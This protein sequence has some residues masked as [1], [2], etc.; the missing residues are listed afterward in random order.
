MT[1]HTI[2]IPKERIGVL[3]GP[4]GKV[5][6]DLEGRAGVYIEIDSE[7]GDV[8]IHDENVFEPVLAL[9]VRDVVR[10]IGRGFPP[11]QAIR[12]FQD[13]SYLD[14]LDITEAVGK[15][16]KDMQ[17]V[18]SRL[19]GTNGKTRATIEDAT[20][21]HMRIYGKTVG[22]VGDIEEVKLAREAVEMIING[23][24]H[25]TVYKFL[26]RKRKELR[27]HDLGL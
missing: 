19:I 7:A 11:D 23:A 3:I 1:I 4:E 9:K 27:L 25:S 20:G 17:R 21:C 10:A 5:K 6:E 13:D 2:R 18:K 24:Q 22:L 12:L 14:I 8:N 16:Q 15:S 26:E